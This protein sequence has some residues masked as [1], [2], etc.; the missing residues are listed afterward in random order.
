M[1]AIELNAVAVD[2]NKMAFEWGCRAAHHW[3]ELELLLQA[4]QVIEF[5]KREPL[6]DLIAKRVAFLTAYQNAAY[7]DKYLGFVNAVRAKEQA[8]SAATS[9]GMF[10]ASSLDAAAQRLPL[11]EAVARN[12]FKLMA[13]KDEYEV[14][15]LHSDG[16]FEAKV[17]AMFEGNYK[18]NYHLAPP[19]LAKKNDKGELQKQQFGP[20]MLSSFKLLSKLKGLR[21][22]VFDVFGKTR[23]R[24]MERLLI[25][26]YQNSIEKILLKLNKV[27]AT[28][29]MPIA[30]DIAKIPESIKGFG[31]VKAKNEATARLKWDALMQ[32]LSL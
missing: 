5:K 32:Q 11:T 4:A 12:L 16:A 9:A 10:P 30:L 17:A 13:Y 25:L 29:T 6:E 21:G 18:L 19:L 14:A 7:A 15:R 31:H 20:W 27:N 26:D 2:N 3:A 22:T 8:L 1:R 28:Q 24:K 23:E